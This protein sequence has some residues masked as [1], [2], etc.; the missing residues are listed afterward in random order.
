M[1]C[2]VYK[3][4]TCL[5]LLPAVRSTDVQPKQIIYV[6]EGN[7]TLGPSSWENGPASPCESVEVALDGAEQYS[8]SI[9]AVKKSARMYLR[10]ITMVCFAPPG[11]C[12][13]H[14]PML[15]ADVEM[16]FIV[17]SGVMSPQK[18]W[19]FLTAIA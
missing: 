6:D 5:L 1:A 12:L 2:I 3:I 15:H 16:T 11:S 10:L 14:Q 8:S 4:T 9:E 13:I 17:L 7:G 19:L 18:R